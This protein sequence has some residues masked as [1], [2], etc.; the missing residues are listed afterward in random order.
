VNSFVAAGI[1]SVST[2]FPQA[3]IVVNAT[4]GARVEIVEM[5]ADGSFVPG[6]AFIS[7]YTASSKPRTLFVR[8]F[9]DTKALCAQ[10]LPP[11]AGPNTLS[12]VYRSCALLQRKPS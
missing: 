5:K 11:P 7:S 2:F 3:K 9:P 6:T 4:P 12:V 1:I 10:I 8:T